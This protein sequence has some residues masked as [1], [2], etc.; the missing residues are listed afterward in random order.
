VTVPMKLCRA[1][2]MPR[3]LALMSAFH[4]SRGMDGSKHSRL[5]KIAVMRLG[6]ICGGPFRLLL[7]S[8]IE[9]L[10]LDSSK[11]TAPQEVAKRNGPRRVAPE[12]GHWGG[13][14]QLRLK[15]LPIG[16]PEFQSA[17]ASMP[18]DQGGLG[19]SDPVASLQAARVI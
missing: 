7:G 1:L 2:A 10:A 6:S 11:L 5:L 16:R 17:W 15:T 8:V 18:L 14:R 3:R 19:P 9:M 4:V 13:S 12:A